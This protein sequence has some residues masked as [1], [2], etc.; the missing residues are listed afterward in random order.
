MF[1]IKC[2]W[3][4]RN[5]RVTA[6]TVFELLRE[7]KSNR[8]G[9]SEITPNHSNVTGHNWSLNFVKYF[10]LKSCL[11]GAVKLVRNA[12]ESKFIYDD[13]GIAFD[14]KS[15]WSFVNDFARTAITYGSTN[16]YWW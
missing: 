15:E 8:K 1:L 10:P 6:F 5:A 14:G 3:I 2:Y 16:Y 13:G 11:L 4:L 9:R 7:G 12:V